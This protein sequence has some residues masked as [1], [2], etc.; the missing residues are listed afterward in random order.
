MTNVSEA[1]QLWISDTLTDSV[2]LAMVVHWQCEVERKEVSF[3]KKLRFS[4][5][6]GST[7][8]KIERYRED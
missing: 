4:A 3:F 6:F 8:T 1:L 2:I 7:Y 5:C